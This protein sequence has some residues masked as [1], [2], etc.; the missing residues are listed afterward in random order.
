MYLLFTLTII[1]ALISLI[2]DVWIIIELLGLLSGSSFNMNSVYL[3]LFGFIF[4][5][6]L[7][8]ILSLIKIKVGN[9]YLK[10]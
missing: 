9:E 7:L 8:I 4:T 3:A 2:G 10:L 6:I 5:T 1:S